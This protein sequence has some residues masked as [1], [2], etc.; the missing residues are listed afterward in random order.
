MELAGNHAIDAQVAFFA[1]T[2][3]MLYL[4]GFGLPRLQRIALS[5]GMATR[6]LGVAF[7][8]LFAIPD[9]DPRAIV[10]VAFG[11]L[12]QASFSFGTASYDGRATRARGAPSTSTLERPSQQ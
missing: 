8:P 4:V 11:V 1:A 10:M 3:I 9:V 6:N 2:T 5:L 12:M 7:A